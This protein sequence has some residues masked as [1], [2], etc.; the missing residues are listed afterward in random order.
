MHWLALS[1]CPCP[2]VCL[3]YLSWPCPPA[4]LPA[5][6]IHT[7]HTCR[8]DR[9]PRC[10]PLRLPAYLQSSAQ[11]QLGALRTALRLG[12]R[13]TAGFG[14]PSASAGVVQQLTLLQRLVAALDALPLGLDL[15]GL[16]VTIGE[17][18]GVDAL[19]TVWLAA[20]GS[21]EAWQR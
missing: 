6:L 1:A 2:L 16:R 19:G 18:N 5:H 21:Q 4:Y 13:I 11:H 12:R 20:E 8:P 10:L 15:S 17:A 9:P 14:E 7:V 3:P